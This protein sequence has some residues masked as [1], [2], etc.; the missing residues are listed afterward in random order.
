MRSA[1]ANVVFVAAFAV[2]DGVFGGGVR[3]LHEPVEQRDAA[4]ILAHERMNGSGT[5]PELDIIEREHARE[6]LAHAFGLQEIWRLYK[7][8]RNLSFVK[9]RM[10]AQGLRR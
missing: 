8:S 5:N 3:M 9:G 4:V 1:A 7:Y 2:V 10:Q 6:L